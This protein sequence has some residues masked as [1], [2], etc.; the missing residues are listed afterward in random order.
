MHSRVSGPGQMTYWEEGPAT[1][2]CAIPSDREGVQVT[3]TAQAVAQD[4]MRNFGST[5]FNVVKTA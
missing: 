4:G 5:T 2:Q 1:T 3:E